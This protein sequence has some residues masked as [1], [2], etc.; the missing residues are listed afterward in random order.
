[1][2][3]PTHPR[4]REGTEAAIRL[5]QLPVWLA[6]SLGTFS[7]KQRDGN[8][9]IGLPLCPLC[10]QKG[11]VCERGRAVITGAEK[12][13]PRDQKHNPLSKSYSRFSNRISCLKKPPLLGFRVATVK[14]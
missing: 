7:T 5:L 4:G 8:G 6:G 2:S 1:M 10:T 13:S 3:Q 12:G 11:G 14:V 9:D